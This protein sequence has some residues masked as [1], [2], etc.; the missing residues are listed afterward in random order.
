MRTPMDHEELRQRFA[1]LTTAHV[2]DACLRAQIPV[3]GAPALLHAVEWGSRLAGRVSPARHVGS[4]DIFLEAVE[5]AAPGD[6]LVV[7]NG[8][9]L[10]EACVGDLVALEAQAAGLEGLVIWGLHRDTADLRAVGLPVFS[11]GAIPTGPNASMPVPIM[12]WRSPRW[13]SGQWVG[14]TWSWAMTMGCS[15]CRPPAL[16]TSSRLRR[17]SATP[18]DAK[19]N[20]CVQVSPCAARCSSSPTLRSANRPLP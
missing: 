11:L 8:G 4:V 14:R 18:S 16:T 20:G 15:S 13:E 19:P 2:A 6:V 3:R 5:G 12:R 1:T 9:R 7:D 17:G 10:D